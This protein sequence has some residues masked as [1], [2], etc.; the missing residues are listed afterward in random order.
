MSNRLVISTERQERD[1]RN[2]LGEIDEA[3]SSD[4]AFSALAAGIP[5][6]MLEPLR[7]SLSA[8][9]RELLESLKA[10]SETKEGKL[11]RA[12]D[13]AGADIGEM[14]VAARLSRNWTQKELARRL[15]LPEQ[16][17]QRYEAEKYRSISLSSLMRVTRTLGVN[18]E[19]NVVDRLDERWLPKTEMSRRELQNVLAHAR[20]NGWLGPKSHTDEGGINYLRRAV[21]EHISDFGAPSLLR[22]G[23]NVHDISNEWLLLAWKAQVAKKAVALTSKQAVRFKLSDLSWLHELVRSSSLEGGPL[24][25]RD[26]LLA[27]GVAMIVEPAP[28]GMKVDGTAF[29]HNDLPVIGM[30]IRHDRE[31]N[32]WFTLIHEVAHIILHYRTGLAAGFFDDIEDQALG[33]LEDQANLFAS[34]L[35]VPSEVW[36]RSPARIAKSPEPIMA[37]AKKLS[38]SPAILFGKARKEREDYRLFSKHVGQG[39]VQRLFE[40]FISQ[41][42]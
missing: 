34:E 4:S 18:L 2:L 15:F 33:D 20:K 28:V 13:R 24:I 11:D 38:I 21:A 42:A 31:D 30:T 25:A 22:T 39:R 10:Y 9:R 27:N 26:I 12:L 40:E 6:V 36:A 3:L 17:V 8:E 29:L 14:L 35:L 1:A 7:H 19:A 32:F 41:N 16:Q 5:Q 37:L 23:L